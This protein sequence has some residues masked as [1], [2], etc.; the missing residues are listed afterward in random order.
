MSTTTPRPRLG[1]SWLAVLAV[2][3]FASGCTTGEPS[4]AP[5]PV[6]TSVATAS[7]DKPAGAT[8]GPDRYGGGQLLQDGLKVP[9][10]SVIAAPL[11]HATGEE[12]SAWY[13]TLLLEEDADPGA[14]LADLADQAIGEGFTVE[15]GDAAFTGTRTGSGYGQ[16][17]QQLRVSVV[18]AFGPVPAHVQ[19][20]ST[21]VPDADTGDGR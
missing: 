21:T 18:P 19:V 6:D 1:S 17:R 3:V 5:T 2:A 4:T 11:G 13:A 7:P 16:G 14:V 15:R 20:V 9:A 12:A 10:G 8:R